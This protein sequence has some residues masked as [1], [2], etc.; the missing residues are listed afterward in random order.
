MSLLSTYMLRQLGIGLV[1]VTGGLAVLIWVTQ[2]LR[3]VELVLNRGLSI[4]VFF[5]LTVFMLPNFIA[6][7]L[8][9]TTFIVI[10]A[11]YNR[12]E[13]DRELVVMRAAGMGPMALAR[14]ALVLASGAALLGWTMN[15]WVVPESATATAVSAASWCTTRARPALRRPS[16]PSAAGSR[17]RATRRA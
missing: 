15:L 5:E 2:S 1:A 14:P 11:V 3:F 9:V 12:M 13:D 6:V 8:P 4:A 17:S 16:W 7:I 10:L